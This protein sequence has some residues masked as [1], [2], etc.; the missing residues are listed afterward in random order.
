MERTEAMEKANAA[1]QSQI[2]EREQ[3]QLL[4]EKISAIPLWTVMPGLSGRVLVERLMTLFA[5]C[6][7]HFHF[8]LH[9]D[10]TARRRTF[11]ATC[12][13]PEQVIYAPTATKGP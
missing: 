5:R 8:Q 4:K 2:A 7:R 6:A 11:A 12:V 3:A 9:G 1:L 10:R 13:F